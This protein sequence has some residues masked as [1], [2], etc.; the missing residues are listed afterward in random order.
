MTSRRKFL[1]QA[2]LL[3]AGLM[4]APRLLSAKATH[5]AGLQ[6]YSLRDQLPK[7]VK[8]V[9][10]KVAAAG[11]KEVETFGY[12]KQ[13]GFWGL[14]AKAFSSLLKAN[15]L[16]T[17]SGHFGM[18]EFLI[19]DKTE[20]L[21]S[22]IEAANATGMSYLVIPS[23]NGEALKS[24]DS[25]KKIAEKMNKAAEI[26]KKSG[27][28]LGYHNHNFEW[29]PIEGTTFY[30]T[31]LKETDP[32]LVHMEMDIFWVVRAGQDPIKL[33]QKHPGRFALCHIKD[34][35]KTQTDLNTEI[36][37][38][39][40]DFKTILSHSGQAGFK[41]FIVEQENYINIDP[42]ISIAES[43]AYVKNVLHV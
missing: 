6:L 20:E 4:I 33:F 21:E 17:P 38:G 15:G 29:K 1:T 32:K 8:G 27:L 40:I 23:I 26:C 28:K 10:A 2:G 39:S 11:Y 43:A 41:H 35:D 3:S 34:R 12:S 18:D 5:V 30:D 13:N 37:K 19:H 31:I 24:A 16:T 42:Y 22:Y 14:D 9:I 7:D 36:G 25:F